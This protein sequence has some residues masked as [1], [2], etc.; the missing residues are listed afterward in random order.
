MTSHVQLRPGAYADSVTPLARQVAVGHSSGAG[1]ALGVT[2]ALGPA[3]GV[4]RP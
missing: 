1:L 3:P 4:S 2:L